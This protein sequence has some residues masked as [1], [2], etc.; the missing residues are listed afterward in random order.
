LQVQIGVF[1][2][3][4]VEKLCEVALDGIQR[5]DWYVTWPS[6]Y[7]PMPLIACIAPEVLNWLSYALY[8][9]KQGSLPLSQRMLDATGA[10]RF[11]APS[12]RHHRGIKTEGTHHKQDI[13]AA[14]N[15]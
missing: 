1:P 4:R 8:N 11:Y 6:M 15:V 12:L 13:D 14:S 9:A 3:V 2:V 10:K 7:L 5:G